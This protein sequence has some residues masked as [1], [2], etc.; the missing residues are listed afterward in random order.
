MPALSLTAAT[1][2]T[3]VVSDSVRHIG[4]SPPGS[5]I[6]GTLQARILEWVAISFSNAW[7]WKMKV[8]LL[9]QVQL[10]ATPWT[11][12]YQAPRSMGFSR[13]EYWSAVYHLLLYLK[14][15][16][17]SF[18]VTTYSS[19]KMKEYQSHRLA[20]NPERNWTYKYTVRIHE[21]GVTHGRMPKNWCFGTVVLE[22]IL[23]RP[24]AYQDIKLV[25]PKINRSWVFTGR[26]DA[27]GEAPICWPPDVKSRLT[28]KDPD[29]GEMKARGEASDR[30]WVVWMASP[31]HWTRVWA[32]PGR[33]ETTGRPGMLQGMGSQNNIKVAYLLFI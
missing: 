2:V 8:K 23:E 14:Y 28:G 27:E 7:K 26:T 32:N 25:N 12:A 19:I 18:S 5:L 13:Q 22:R 20:V 29:A 33:Q 16:T 24:L 3:S 11:A 17:D 6:P 1:A 31:T 15:I 4:G 10:L 30:G 21:Q 9:S